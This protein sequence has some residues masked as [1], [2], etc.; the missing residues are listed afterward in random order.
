MNWLPYEKWEVRTPVDV[1]TL[2]GGL[3]KWV[4]PYKFLQQLTPWQLD[5][6]RFW[7]KVTPDGFR[8]TRIVR[9]GN[10]FKPVIKGKF[11]ESPDG[12]TIR[13]TMNLNTFVIAFLV[14]L[15]V[16][17]VLY[18][19][20]GLLLFSVEGNTFLLLASLGI[21]GFAAALTDF[22]FWSEVA[23]AKR[24]LTEAIAQIEREAAAAP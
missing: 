14:F 19:L 22:G 10:S 8:I 17:F 24:L 13:V 2:V 23:G 20:A 4:V 11:L 9:R 1:P 5:T 15:F 3:Q 12:T 7:G 21:V 6:N 16:M 18:V